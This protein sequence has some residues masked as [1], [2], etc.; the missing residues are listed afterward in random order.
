M[1]IKEKINVVVLFGGCSSE[2][3]VSLE[4]AGAILQKM[5]RDRFVPVP[6]GITESGDW[7]H[8]FGEVEHILSDMWF[9]SEYCVPAVLSS[10][11]KRKELL[12]F[13]KN[14]LE[15]KRVQAVF[16][17]L[18]GK[19]GED[20][21]VQGLCELAGIPVVGCGT[22]SSALCMDKERAHK[23]VSVEGLKVPKSFVLA[24]NFDSR[25]ALE[26]GEAIGY[27]LFVKPVKAGSSHGINKVADRDSLQAAL[28]EALDYDDRVIVEEAISG[29]EV[30]CA[31]MG[32]ETLVAGELDEIEI[33][34]DFFDFT[35]KYNLFTSKIHVPAR[36]SPE[37][38]EELKCAAKKI[39]RALDCSGFARVDMFL[40]PS[41]EIYFNEVNTIPGFTL[42]S[43]FPNMMKAVGMT[44]D[45]V[46]T[47]VIELAVEHE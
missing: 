6:V 35:E 30:G 45:Q 23:L 40:I 32:R 21:T 13:G 38:S 34:G 11:R 31:V 9:D 4:S 7:Y 18:H 15:K 3:S 20:G 46:I 26:Q 22:L 24:K 12:V 44:F 16:P 41:G 43:R 1:E 37:R 8:Y 25:L 17:V 29:F 47:R 36:V 27:P 33:T 42:H 10:D 19:N 2:Y 39:Y 5:D 28:L 14:G